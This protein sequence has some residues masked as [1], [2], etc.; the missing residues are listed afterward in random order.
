MTKYT[1]TL[2]ENA[3]GELIMPLSDEMMSE[4]GWDVGTRIK[5]IDNFDGSWTMQKVETEWVLVETVSTFRHR[6]MVEVPVGKAEWAC[7]TVV[8]DEA[9]EFSQEHLGFH[10]VSNRV[11]GLEEALEICVEDNDYCATWSDD[12]KIEVFFTEIKE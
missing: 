8:M 12:K 11:V 5:W 4:L 3:D 9:V 1:I 2:E 7:D 6:Y 10:I